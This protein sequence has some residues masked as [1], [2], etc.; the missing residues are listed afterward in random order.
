[1]EQTKPVRSSMRFSSV[2]LLAGLG[3]AL[4]LASTS[5]LAA[6]D[7]GTCSASPENRQL[8]F[9][10]GNWSV[11]YPGM[12]GNSASKVSLDLDKCLVVESWEGGMSHAGKNM[13]AYSADDKSWH[14][15]FADNQ[16][17]VH[18]F[19][20]KISDGSAEFTGPS[21]APDGKAVLNRIKIAR[22]NENKVVQS[23]EKSR[24]NGVTWTT[25][26]RGEYSRKNQ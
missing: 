15:L 14:G 19:E 24:D 4:C 2:L 8:D 18:V 25:E 22:V 13:F 9:W 16:G 26:F 5:T 17:R 1:M 7:T 10:I 23:W 12:A 6:P 11:T 21:R 20:G 3:G